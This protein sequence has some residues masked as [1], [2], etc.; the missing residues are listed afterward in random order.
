MLPGR[1]WCDFKGVLLLFFLC[2][3][4]RRY[5]GEGFD[6]GGGWSVGWGACKLGGEGW[7]LVIAEHGF[8]LGLDLVVDGF[9]L[10]DLDDLLL[11]ATWG[12]GVYLVFC[13]LLLDLTFE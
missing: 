13:E 12:D 8:E 2:F 11:L 7:G 10:C 3:L 6:L 1:G 9:G 4:L 5:S